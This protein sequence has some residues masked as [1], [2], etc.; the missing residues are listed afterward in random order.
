MFDYQQTAEAEG[1][2]S[3]AKVWSVL[4]SQIWT[5]LPGYCHGTVDLKAVWAAVYPSMSMISHAG[6]ALTTTFSQLL[7]QLVYSQQ[8][9]RPAILKA[10]KTM[11][12]SNV[13]LASEDNENEKLSRIE[14]IS[15]TAAQENVSFL[16]TQAD[17][18]LAVLFNV[19]GTVDREDRGKIGDVIRVWAGV[20]KQEVWIG[21]CWLFRVH[22]RFRSI[23][24]KR[25]QK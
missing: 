18:W 17:S 16:R 8:E 1:R 13:S 22:S 9:L 15:R 4:V 5:G 14:H 23:F 2:A 25:L 12:D 24:L 11:V 3:E 7:S 21:R 10:L 19:F 6:Q 20:A